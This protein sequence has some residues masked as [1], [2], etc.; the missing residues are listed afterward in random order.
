MNRIHLTLFAATVMG[1]HAQ[2]VQPDLSDRWPAHPTFVLPAGMTAGIDSPESPAIRDGDSM[3]LGVRLTD[4]DLERVWFLRLRVLADV[5]TVEEH[6]LNYVVKIKD[7]LG[8]PD[9]SSWTV[10]VEIE[11]LDKAGASKGV[12]VI[13]LPGRLIKR[14]LVMGCRVERE[15][16][17]GVIGQDAKPTLESLLPGFTLFAFMQSVQNEEMLA[18]IL[19]QVIDPPSLFGLLT[20][21]GL[22]AT[23]SADFEDA[24][25][26]YTEIAGRQYLAERLPFKIEANDEPAFFGELIAVDPVSPLSTSA[27]IVYIVGRKPSRLSLQ[28]EISVLGARRGGPLGPAVRVTPSGR[29][30]MVDGYSTLEVEH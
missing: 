13:L 27:G 12:S 14:G 24:I 17:G 19:W 6:P 4:E 8:I 25:S 16:A 9:Y 10:P 15:S 18:E 22:T 11:L 28:L 26:G 7:K 1:C 5:A 3:L 20:R 30:R 29:F 21:G 2:P 23:L